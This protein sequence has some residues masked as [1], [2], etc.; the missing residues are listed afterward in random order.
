MS[1]KPKVLIEGPHFNVVQC[2]NCFRIGFYYKNI[3]IGFDEQDFIAFAE[4]YASINFKECC[5]KFSGSREHIILNTCHQDIQLT[6]NYQEFEGL[7]ELLQ[8]A[9]MII[10]ANRILNS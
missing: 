6:F 3:L 2:A 4:E 1:C 5:V 10:E 8:Q 7:Q 9:R